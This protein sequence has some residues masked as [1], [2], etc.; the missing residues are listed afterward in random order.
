MLHVTWEWIGI[1]EPALDVANTVAIEKD[2]PHDL[3]EPEGEY[4]RWARSAASSPG[5]EPAHPGALVDAQSHLLKLRDDIR[6]VLHA[7]AS[8][9][10]P[11]GNHVAAL[12]RA[13][14]AAPT[15]LE[16]GDDGALHER[17]R[18]D[19][20]EQL[21]AAY[22]RSAIRIAAEGSARL[23]VCGA[24]S[25]GM[26]YRPTRRQQ[27]WCSVQCGTRARVARHYEPRRRA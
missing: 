16:L 5:L 7:A 26:F 17:A 21:L 8:G 13:T 4:R 20:I 27:R 3:L 9:Q 10:P 2:V 14:A 12:N 25:C 23:R 6:A 11:P 19:A 24:P 18:G 15:W 1:D 22:A